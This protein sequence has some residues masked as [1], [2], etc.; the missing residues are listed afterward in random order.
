MSFVYPL[1]TLILSFTPAINFTSLLLTWRSS[2]VYEL[3]EV[4]IALLISVDYISLLI[5]LLQWAVVVKILVRSM[6]YGEFVFFSFNFV[7]NKVISIQ[8]L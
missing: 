7:A 8:T 5:Y 1:L 4:L 3:A 2:V 6:G